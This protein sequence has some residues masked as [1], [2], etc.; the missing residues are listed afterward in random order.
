[1]ER[2][3]EPRLPT[4][5]PVRVQVLRSGTMEFPGTI[6]NTSGR[7]LRV[8]LGEAL[9]EGELI[10]L[11]AENHH[12]IAVVR[13][14]LD[15]GGTFAAGIERTDEWQ[16]LQQDASLPDL[17]ATPQSQG[18]AEPL[19]TNFGDVRTAALRELFDSPA[20]PRPRRARKPLVFAAG[21]GM[22]GL[23]AVAGVALFG[24]GSR[25]A[26]VAEAQPA[27]ASPTSPAPRPATG[28]AAAADDPQAGEAAAGVQP[29]GKTIVI[30]ARGDSW[31][32]GCAD[33]TR[34]F[35][36]LFRAGDRAE[37]LYTAEALLRAGNAAAVD[38]T[39]AGESLGP[40][41]SNSGVRAV[42]FTADGHGDVPAENVQNCS[43][44]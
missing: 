1:M 28:T 42:R 13:Y 30:Q 39:V 12:T 35:E 15:A 16:A 9:K 22:V 34:V 3:S 41:G 6:V 37:L 4:Q 27:D 33:G 25:L 23:A 20:P 29:A 10:R 11:I 36:K 7:G 38:I 24:P 19:R 26:P 21:V 8:H 43:G 14:C 2:R 44:Q 17:A 18:N 40:L 32:L 31:V 5:T